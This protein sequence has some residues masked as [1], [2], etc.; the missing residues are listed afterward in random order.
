MV[1]KKQLIIVVDRIFRGIHSLPVSDV[2]LHHFFL[3][4]TDKELNL[5]YV[6]SPVLHDHVETTRIDTEVIQSSA[7]HFAKLR[8]TLVYLPRM[9]GR[10]YLASIKMPVSEREE[11][12]ILWIGKGK[13]DAEIAQIMHVSASMIRVHIN[14]LFIRYQVKSRSERIQQTYRTTEDACQRQASCMT[15]QY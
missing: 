4:L 3:L 10:N 2:A 5:L 14:N 15:S 13:K 1:N 6:Y 8:N 9:E 7:F 11:E 12:I